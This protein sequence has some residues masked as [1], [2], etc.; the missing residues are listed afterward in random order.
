VPSS[1][2]AGVVDAG[3]TREVLRGVAGMGDGLAAAST[4]VILDD[5]LLLR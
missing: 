2:A 3:Y 1:R 5:R 4:V